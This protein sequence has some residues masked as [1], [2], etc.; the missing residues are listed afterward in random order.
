MNRLSALAVAAIPVSILSCTSIRHVRVD[1]VTSCAPGENSGVAVHVVDQ[2]GAYLPGATV[3][4]LDATGNM[5]ERRDADRYGVATFTRL[6]GSGMC[7]L[8]GQL[9]GFEVTVAR[10]FSCVPQCL[11]VVTLRMHVDMR[12]AVSFT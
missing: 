9:P 2:T 8:R 7:A 4:L 10:K 11:T 1:P 3:T 5:I 12:N 6:P